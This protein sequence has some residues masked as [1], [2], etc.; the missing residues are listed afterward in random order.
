MGG[1]PEKYHHRSSSLLIRDGDR[2]RD[3]DRPHTFISVV[4]VHHHGPDVALPVQAN[5]LY[6]LEQLNG[7]KSDRYAGQL[8]L[9]YLDARR[10]NHIF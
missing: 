10:V 8:E 1:V 4:L 6:L 2:D 9:S 7:E 5:F 3:R